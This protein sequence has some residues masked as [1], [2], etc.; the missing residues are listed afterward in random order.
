SAEIR[1][2]QPQTPQE[3]PKF[4]PERYE[5]IKL[6]GQ[7]GMGAVYHCMD[8]QLDRPVAIKVMTDKFRSSPQGETRF[9]REA[10][11]QAIVNHTNVST[12]LNFGVSPEGK[13][14]L[15]MEYLEGED[16]RMFLRRQGGKVE[17]MLAC[18]V[19]RQ[20]LE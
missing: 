17:P 15:V 2:D 9:M 4:L 10:R 12:I 7:G 18:E 13:L 16:L 11:A 8:K 6:L 14:F 20:A 5:P 19:M 3:L 1:T